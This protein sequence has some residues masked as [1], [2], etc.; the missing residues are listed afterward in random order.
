MKTY[1]EQEKTAIEPEK[2]I[3][4][5]WKGWSEIFS[6]QITVE[7]VDR[8]NCVYTAKPRKFPLTY[9]VREGNLFITNIDGPFELR[10]NVLYNNNIPVFEKAA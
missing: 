8:R 2:L 1:E 5:R 6:N 10:G 4:T 9:N 3:G 7:F